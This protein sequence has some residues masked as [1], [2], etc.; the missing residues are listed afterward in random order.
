M[1]EGIANNS[2]SLA[3][4][5]TEGIAGVSI[6]SSGQWV[7]VQ[8]SSLT[9]MFHLATKLTHFQ[10]FPNT[11]NATFSA[12]TLIFSQSSQIV[13]YEL[14]EIPPDLP[15]WAIALIALAALFFITI[16]ILV[17]IICGQKTQKKSLKDEV[18]QQKEILESVKR[19][20][21]NVEEENEMCGICFEGE[22]NSYI[23]CNHYFHV[24]CIDKWV[25]ESER[26]CPICSRPTNELEIIRIK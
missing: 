13:I 9:N 4:S 6:D 1:F 23:S 11:T 22:C 18:Q 24:R 12:A 21:E 7:A 5:N 3:A 19:M 14:V 2:I 8:H 17:F 25:E 16:L 10:Q 26:S 20:R 15:Q